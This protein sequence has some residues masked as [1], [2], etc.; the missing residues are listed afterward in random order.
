M[1]DI[2]TIRMDILGQ[3]VIIDGYVHYHV[4]R[5]Y[6]A[7]ADGNRATSRTF[8]EGITDI[9]AIDAEGN[10][11]QLTDNQKE[12]AEEALIRKFMED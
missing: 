3:E 12:N 9:E 1:R 2:T 8:V 10:D 7:D 5:N 4:D 6:G 11:V